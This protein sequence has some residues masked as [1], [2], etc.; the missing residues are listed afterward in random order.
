[1]ITEID[2]TK[3]QHY[4]PFTRD[5][6]GSI[7]YDSYV[8]GLE[9]ADETLKNRLLG[10][11]LYYTL[12]DAWASEEQPENTPLADSDYRIGCTLDELKGKVTEYI[13][14]EAACQTLGHHNVMQ[15]SVGGF[16][17][18]T[19]SQEMVASQTRVDDLR[20]ECRRI[21]DTAYDSLVLMLIGNSYT[22]DMARD[23][24]RW[25]SVT[26]HF[27]WTKDQ[28][29]RSIGDVDLQKT[30]AMAKA[31]AKVETVISRE[32]V[33]ALIEEM[34]SGEV[35]E[36]S[37]VAIELIRAVYAGEMLNG[38]TYTVD[39]FV[40]TTKL[41]AY[42]D[43]HLDSFALYAASAQYEALHATGFKNEP[44]ASGYWL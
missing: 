6:R 19:G 42:M 37:A 28:A 33:K 44:S 13:C 16:T 29:R 11:Q 22:A 36:D 35:S 2:Q 7:I 9:M 4:L 8:Q 23:S 30:G 38:D 39:S 40:A 20:E 1:M 34:R 21:A 5:V 43:E 17:T 26:Q 24:H 31:K 14:N 41:L 10:S 18:A 25:L 15:S 27:I 32:Q 3:L 12:K